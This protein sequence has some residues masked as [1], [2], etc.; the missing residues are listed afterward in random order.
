MILDLCTGGDLSFHL[1]KREIFDLPV[2]TFLIAEIMLAI[3]YIHSLNVIYRDLKPE[4]IL[5]D[6]EGHSKLADFG[7]AKENIDNKNFAK[8]FCGSPA[9]LAPEMLTEKG[10]GRPA[11]IYQMG[12]VLY[13]LLFGIPPFYT[14]NIKKLYKNIATAKLNVP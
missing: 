6:H 5:I 14:D 11:D 13:E 8:S 4:N 12:A 7:L 2:A 10:V 1:S 3:E 9:Y